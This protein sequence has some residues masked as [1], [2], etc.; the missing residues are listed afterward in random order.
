MFS[1]LGES[2][3]PNWVENSFPVI[4]FIILILIVL[5]AIALI[6]LVLMQTSDD[7]NTTNSITGIDSSPTD[8]DFITKSHFS[9]IFFSSGNIGHRK[10]FISAPVTFLYEIPLKEL[11]CTLLIRTI[12]N[13]L[14]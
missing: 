3:L 8:L 5:A 7:N 2:Y 10:F 9:P 11:F 12:I 1:L 4:K 6:A 14:T 13:L